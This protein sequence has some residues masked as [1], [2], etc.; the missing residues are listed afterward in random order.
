MPFKPGAAI[1]LVQSGWEAYRRQ[2]E[3]AFRLDDWVKGKQAQIEERR[4]D[5]SMA[6]A[7]GVYMPDGQGSTK[8]YADL[9]SRSPEN[10]AGL[11]VTNMAQSCF[12]DGVYR[13]GQNKDTMLRSWLNWQE[14]G[15]DRVQNAIYRG[16]FGQGVSY[17]LALPARSALTGDPTSLW[18]GK[19][20]S[21]MAAFYEDEGNDEFPLFALDATVQTVED[22][23]DGAT[24]DIWQVTL[25]DEEY[26]YFLEADNEGFD[27][28]DWRFISREPHG[29]GVT[30]VVRYA[31]QMDLD[32]ITTGEVEPIIPLLRRIDQDVFDRL[33]VQRFGAWKIRYATGLAKPQT[34]EERRAAEAILRMGELLVS[35]DPHSKF[36]TLDASSIEEFIKAHD[37]D[38]RTLAALTQMPPYHLLGLSSNLQSEALETA[39][40]GLRRRSFERQ[41]SFGESHETLFRLSAKQRGDL[42]EMRAFDMQSR[43]RDM[44]T[45]TLAGAADA[46]GKLATQV[47]VPQELLFEMIPGWTDIDVQRAL[48]LVESGAVESLFDAIARQRETVPPADEPP[49]EQ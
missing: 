7:G 5:D 24:R 19:S 35:S 48:S 21:R 36:G 42:E 45:R 17:V 29:S 1:E 38:L 9:V 32:G 28:K 44:E 40:D 46:L 10:W 33:V 20:A 16:A 39:K 47:G 30:P 31:N 12:L 15:F 8:E 22:G 49:V 4:G 14:N 41:V 13:P 23:R 2:R 37:V 43:W 6:E 18:R 34:T 25:Y 27:D 11:I 26:L 3:N